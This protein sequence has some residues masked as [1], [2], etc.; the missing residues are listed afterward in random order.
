[1]EQICRILAVRVYS[2]KKEKD[3]AGRKQELEQM[4]ETLTKRIGALSEEL[5]CSCTTR[6]LIYNQFGSL[7]LCWLHIFA[8]NQFSPH[9]FMIKNTSVHM[10]GGCRFGD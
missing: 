4:V 9:D 6:K 8:H 1:M 10:S 7:L 3:K 2:A 5:V